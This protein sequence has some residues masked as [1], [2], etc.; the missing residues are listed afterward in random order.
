MF[1]VDVKK[2]PRQKLNYEQECQI[3]SGKIAL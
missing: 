1:E 3:V 2:H